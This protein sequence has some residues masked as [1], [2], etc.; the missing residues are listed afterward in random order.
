MEA[1]LSKSM[2]YYSKTYR[3]CLL[4]TDCHYYCMRCYFFTSTHAMVRLTTCMI[5][6]LKNISEIPKVKV[7]VWDHMT[8]SSSLTTS[9]I[10]SLKKIS[11]IPK[12]K[13]LVCY[14]Q[15]ESKHHLTSILTSILTS[16]MV[17][18]KNISEIP[19]L[20]VLV[21]DHMTQSRTR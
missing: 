16:M 19:K 2:R 10:V 4:F 6:S 9:M 14:I 18:L 8:Q 17:S 5:V 3:L 21:W 13:V 7:L 1:F 15:R 11:E 12:V 20:K